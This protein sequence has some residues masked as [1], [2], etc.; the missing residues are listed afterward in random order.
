MELHT[1]LRDDPAEVGRARRMVAAHLDH[2]GL[3]DADQVTALLVSELVT[4]ALLHGHPPLELVARDILTGVRI[5]VHDNNPEGAPYKREHAAA[6]QSGRGLQLVDVLAARWGWSE[7][8]S[9]LGKCVWF[10]V[11]LVWQPTRAAFNGQAG[12]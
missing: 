6:M 7:S 9:G 8:T 5:E 10:E 2:W 1:V 3:K 12:R 4:N 11:D